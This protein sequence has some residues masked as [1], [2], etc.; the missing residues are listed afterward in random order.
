[1]GS[2]DAVISRLLQSSRFNMILSYHSTA[3]GEE[4]VAK[5]NT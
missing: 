2:L 5:G 1:M 3:T 4:L